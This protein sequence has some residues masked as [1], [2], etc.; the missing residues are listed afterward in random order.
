MIVPIALAE[1]KTVVLVPLG[2]GINDFGS[3]LEACSDN[4]VEYAIVEQDNFT[5]I[6]PLEG[7]AE[8]RRYLKDTFGL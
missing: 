8:S 2:K 3:I 1:K 6:T 5:G 4:N 7:M